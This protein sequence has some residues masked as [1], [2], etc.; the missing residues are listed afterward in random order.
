MLGQPY[1]TH[2]KHVQAVTTYRTKHTHTFAHTCNHMQ[3]CFCVMWC[4][5]LWRSMGEQA[6]TIKREWIMRLFI[7]WSI[8]NQGILLRRS[9]EL[10]SF[11]PALLLS[12]SSSSS[13]LAFSSTRKGNRYRLLFFLNFFAVGKL[14][15]TLYHSLCSSLATSAAYWSQDIFCRL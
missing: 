5:V 4:R 1:Y 8:C 11:Q 14:F 2:T 12:S 15:L 10:F 7:V 6:E 9:W 13:L 3:T